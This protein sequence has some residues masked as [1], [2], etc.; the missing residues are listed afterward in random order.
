M[1]TIEFV[2]QSAQDSSAISAN[3]SRLLNL[4][5]ER[6]DA[7]GTT[8][9]LLRSVPGQRAVCTFTNGLLRKMEWV[10]GTVF[11]VSGGALYQV[12]NAIFFGLRTVT[13]L[14][15]V[16]DDVNTD[17]SGNNG[18][19]TITAGG[20]YYVWDG[21]TLTQPTGA[22]FTQF[23]SVALLDNYSLLTE[24]NGRRIQWTDLADPKTFDALNFATT[25]S[26]QDDNI[27]GMV[28]GGQYWVF[29]ER[30]T[31]IWYN[32]GQ[33]GA[34]AFARVPGGLIEKGLKGFNLVT[35]ARDLAF[36]VG[37]D[38]V[39][40]LTSGSAPQPVSTRAVEVALQENDPTHCYYYEEFGH[41]FCVIRFSD[42]PAWVF[43]IAAAEWHERAEGSTFGPWNAVCSVESDNGPYW[44]GHADGKAYRLENINL[45][46]GETLYR[47]AV[48]RTL[49]VDGQRFRGKEFEI[50]GA[51]GYADA[52][53]Q[54][55]LSF[56]GDSGATFGTERFL[57]MGALGDYDNRVLVRSFGQYRQLTAQMDFSH[58]Y[59]IPVYADARIELA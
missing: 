26:R 40:Y 58:A 56:S 35:K 55:M 24:L 33:A 18:S 54:L 1:P 31:E 25:E 50:Y 11:G 52:E 7:G 57:S 53:T 10:D 32:T 13:N 36:F 16:V 4:Y 48:S 42:R 39:A 14:G 28:I 19:V 8:R 30:S 45:D 21:S 5:R 44:V 46:K 51:Y 43:D 20:R 2:G 47:R 34:D 3:T 38:N 15:A 23:G 17:I 59:E 37:T 49:R 22:A 29:K 41:K 9:Y 12:N 27:R 6:V